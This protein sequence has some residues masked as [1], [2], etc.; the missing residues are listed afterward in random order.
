MQIDLIIKIYIVVMAINS[1][2]S[3]I[4]WK[5]YK[6]EIYKMGLFLWLTYL[7]NFFT[8]GMFDNQPFLMILGFSTYFAIS[9]VL[10]RILD[11]SL[12]EKK[13][14]DKVYV[15]G[16]V[17]SLILSYVLHYFKFGFTI[18]AIPVALAVTI[19]QFQAVYALLTDRATTTSSKVF[20]FFIFINALHLLDYPFLRMTEFAPLGFTIAFILIL[21]FSLVLP[22]HIMNEANKSYIK[23]LESHLHMNRDAIKSA[24]NYFNILDKTVIENVERF[25]ESAKQESLML[26]TLGHD[27]NGALQII[28]L[29]NARISKNVLENEDFGFLKK[30]FEKI[31]NSVSKIMEMVDSVRE[32]QKVAAKNL[33]DTTSSSSILSIADEL[34][35]YFEDSLNEKNIVLKFDYSFKNLEILGDVNIL[36]NHIL[37][38]LISNAIKFS[39]K[40]SVIVVKFSENQDHYFVSVIDKGVGL[41]EEDKS[42][43]FNLGESESKVGTNGERGSAIGL[44][45]VSRYVG[46]LNGS[47]S[48]ESIHKKGTSFTVALNKVS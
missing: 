26:S 25:R 21:C 23:E 2:V 48:V 22:A 31:E 10:R 38:N 42:K 39:Y 12:K 32:I 9:I 37:T 27:I 11:L 36:K 34:T 13:L 14:K 41:T 5:S 8:Q 30:N 6:N 18:A 24:G 47:I 1:I 3:F 33:K 45:L 19:P 40:Q 16:Y 17:F 46:I 29:S 43:I 44:S 4:F 35:D 20:C 7:I 28:L 15:Y